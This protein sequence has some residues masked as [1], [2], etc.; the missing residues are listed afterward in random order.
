M[1]GSA[2]LF[3]RICGGPTYSREVIT[4]F[5]ILNKFFKK[6]KYYGIPDG[7]WFDALSVIEYL[8]KKYKKLGIEKM[9]SEEYEKLIKSIKIPKEHKWQDKLI[10]ITKED[11]IYK[12]VESSSGEQSIKI[13]NLTFEPG[14][15][16]NKNYN[17][18]YLMH[19]DCY[20]IMKEKVKS[21]R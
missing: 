3:C 12:N 6:N 8:K 9:N 17:D 5:L 20:K 15:C 14:G 1:D 16:G 2:D 19:C 7:V 18:S 10:L 4:N 13:N 21:K 11:K